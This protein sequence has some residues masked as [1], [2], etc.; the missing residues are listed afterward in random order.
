MDQSSANHQ[1]WQGASGSSLRE[2]VN[3]TDLVESCVESLSFT[4]PMLCM[5]SFCLQDSMAAMELLDPK[6]DSCE[7]PAQQIQFPSAATHG[8]R[9]KILYPRPTPTGIDDDFLPLPWE[10]L[11]LR[12]SCLIAVE[13]LVR[14]ESMLGGSSVV[15]SIYTCLYAHAEVCEDM[16][17]R[18][19]SPGSS[20]RGTVAQH[21]VYSTTLALVEIS[22]IMRSI[23]LQGDI[24]EEEDFCA[25]TYSVPIYSN[26]EKGSTLQ[27]LSR[28]LSMVEAENGLNDADERRAVICILGFFMDLLSMSS[29]VVR[30]LG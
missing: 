27:G 3:I 28:A 21:V 25:N 20:S 12:D 8:D 7:I 29:G 17:S 5:E 26:T 13:G 1:R 18:L 9:D 11:T 14:L 10:K 19:H 24:Y 2:A 16:K 22:E 30:Y 15:E 23:V 6:M 4:R